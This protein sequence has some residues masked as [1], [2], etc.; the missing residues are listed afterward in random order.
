MNDELRLSPVEEGLLGA[1]RALDRQI[2]K[3][4]VRRGPSDLETFGVT[5]WE[6]YRKR[7]ERVA[8]AALQAFSDNDVKLDSLLVLSQSLVKVIALVVDELGVEG[9]GAMRTAYSAEACNS[10]ADDAM[11]AL[12]LLRAETVAN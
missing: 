12:R 11:R 5:R 6:P 8:S 7:M 2:E 3:E 4:L 1:M 9:L 10:I